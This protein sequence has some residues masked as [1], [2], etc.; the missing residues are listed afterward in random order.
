M[1]LPGD[2]L[3]N[4]LLLRERKLCLAGESPC[5]CEQH[6]CSSPTPLWYKGFAERLYNASYSHRCSAA[7]AVLQTGT[8]VQGMENFCPHL[9]Y[10]GLSLASVS[11]TRQINRTHPDVA[12]GHPTL[13]WEV[14]PAFLI[15][16]TTT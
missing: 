14:T 13:G 8:E 12:P 5:A 7:Q 1:A 9:V 16:D 4:G 6:F 11:Q 10:T 15:P 3:A 2:R